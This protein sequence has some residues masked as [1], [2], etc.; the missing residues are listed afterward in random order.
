[1]ALQGHVSLVSPINARVNSVRSDGVIANG[2]R[3]RHARPPN[4]L[5]TRIVAW[6]WEAW[7]AWLRLGG[8]SVWQQPI[9]LRTDMIL[10]MVC[11]LVAILLVALVVSYAWKKISFRKSELGIDARRP[12]MTWGTGLVSAADTA[13]RAW[14]PVPGGT[15]SARRPD[16]GRSPSVPPAK[17]AN[18]QA[19]APVDAPRARA[20]PGSA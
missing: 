20:R 1:M 15:A 16:T 10:N 2:A 13:I 14:G 19:A 7:D 8:G 6:G 3:T 9:P 18:R 11:L 17:P 4:P 5:H 12:G